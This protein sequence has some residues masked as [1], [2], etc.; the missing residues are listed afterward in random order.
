MLNTLY[1]EAK[2]TQATAVNNCIVGQ[3]GLGLS[4]EDQVAFDSSLNDADF[5]SRNLLALYKNAGASFGLTSLLCHRNGDCGCR[6]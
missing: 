4:P 2:T 3:W 1:T 5:S 6:R